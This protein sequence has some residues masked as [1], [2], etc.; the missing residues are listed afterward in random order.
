MKPVFEVKND[1]KRRIVYIRLSGLFD[2]ETLRPWCEVYRR[3]ATAPYKDRRHIVIADMRGMK[4]VRP[5]VAALFGAEIGYARAH[6]TVLCVH[7]SD[8]TV[9]RLQAA[10]IARQSSPSDDVTIDVDSV[11]EAERTAQ[12]YAAYLDDPRYTTS[13]R[14]A[15]ENELCGGRSEASAA[16]SGGGR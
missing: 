4:T 3:K 8:D 13:I 1:L 9:Q 15:L 16:G 14:R 12:A 11:E 7:V 10:R 5:N 2:E 6:G